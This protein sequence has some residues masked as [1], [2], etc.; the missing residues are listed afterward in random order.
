[1][2]TSC[3]KPL[4][5]NRSI[6]RS[7]S[8]NPPVWS[9]PNCKR[10]FTRKN[11]R[12]ACGTGSRNEVL[13]NRPPELVELYHAVEAFAKSLGKIE[14]VARE[15]YVLLRTVRI[16]AD[17]VVMSDA[18]RL[19][20]HLGR[21][22]NDP[23]FFKVAAD[24]RHTSHVAKLRNARDLATIKPYLKEAYEFSLRKSAKQL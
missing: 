6:V 23:I 18:L 2:T 24:A 22:V 1:M 19:A 10:K 21:K 9:C 11:Q 16:F 12:H 8:P 4:I 7:Y 13:R 20:I 15:R 17:L 5:A 3:A 14:I